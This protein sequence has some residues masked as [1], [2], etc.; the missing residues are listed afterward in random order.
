[1]KFFDTQN[2]QY[3][4]IPIREQPRTKTE[5]KKMLGYLDD[6]LKRPFNTSGVDD[7]SMNLKDSPPDMSTKRTTK[8]VQPMGPTSLQDVQQPFPAHGLA[9]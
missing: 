3:T 7:R 1:L 4:N 2:I 8:P 6:E 5:P 9:L